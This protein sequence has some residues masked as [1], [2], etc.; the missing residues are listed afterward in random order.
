[1]LSKGPHARGDTS[2][3][4]CGTLL[5]V[6]PHDR[7]TRQE[8]S[9][10][11]AQEARGAARALRDGVSQ[12]R[13]PSSPHLELGGAAP[14]ETSLD[15][16]DDAINLLSDLQ[17]STAPGKG[18]R[19]RIDLAS[20]L[21]DIAPAARLTMTPGAGTEVFGEEGELRRLLHV[22]LSQSAPGVPLEQATPD[23]SIGRQE[24]LVRIAL[25]LGPDGS[26]GAELERRWLSRTA[27]RHGGHV[28]L[29]GNVLALLLPADG[30]SDQRE[31]AQLRR[32]LEQAQQLGE[33]YARELAS[34][35]ASAPSPAPALAPSQ[36]SR[37]RLETMVGS[38]AV[39]ARHLRLLADALDGDAKLAA[40]A[41]GETS[42]LATALTQRVAA[43]AELTRAVGR[44]GACALDEAPSPVDLSALCDDVIASAEAQAQ[45]YGVKIHARLIPCQRTLPRAPLT[46]LVRS[47]L[48]HG[49]A[50]SP[51]GSEVWLQLG[52]LQEGLYLQI[53]D[54]GPTVPSGARAGLL[55]GVADPGALGRPDSI[56]LIVGFAAARYLSAELSL[57]ESSEGR[58]VARLQF[59]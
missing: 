18:R 50:A 30:A 20:L 3:A 45:R 48:D 37:E 33:A 27:V 12:L 40:S 39:L 1:M 16:L 54:H 8:L 29:E 51:R 13:A 49:I 6:S 19:G 25:P 57:G 53:E 32:E 24:G 52:E 15:A 36:E 23:I 41:L 47:L 59:P 4:V 28:E 14:V 38:G 44:I 7:L 55:R 26:S 58:F 56:G 10:L 9:W 17:S 31:V 46:L 2:A 43:A 21:C 42:E 11:L 35:F 5:A 22:L 34:V